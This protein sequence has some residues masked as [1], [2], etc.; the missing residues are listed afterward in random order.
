MPDH[1]RE[2][3]ARTVNEADEVAGLKSGVQMAHAKT[4]VTDIDQCAGDSLPLLSTDG[5]HKNYP[6]FGP[7]NGSSSF[8]RLVR[9]TCVLVNPSAGMWKKL[10]AVSGSLQ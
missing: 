6:V 9:H 5:R 1:A 4:V 7:A 8:L 10:R 2:A 3:F